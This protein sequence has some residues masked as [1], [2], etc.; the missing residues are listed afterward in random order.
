MWEKT[1]LLLPLPTDPNGDGY[2]LAICQTGGT[3][4]AG[5]GGGAPTCTAGEWC[6]SSSTSASGSQNSCAYTIQQS[7]AMSNAWEAYVCDDDTGGSSCTEAAE[8]GD[9]PFNVNHPP[10]IGTVTIGPSY[11]SSSSVNPGNDTTGAVY[12]QVAVTD[13]D[14]EAPQDTID[15][16]VCSGGTTG[17]EAST[18]TCTGGTLLC[19]D[20]GVTTGTNAQCTDSDLA[21][22]PTSHGSKNVKIYLRDSSSTPLQDDGS[23]NSH[24]YAVTDVTPTV[25]NFN[26]SQDPLI[27][28]AGLSTDQSFTATLTDENGY[29]DIESAFGAIYVSP[30]TLTGTGTCTTDSELNCYD[31]PSCELSGGSGSSVTVTCGTAGNPLTTWFNIAPDSSW[32]AHVSAVGAITYSLENRRK[33]HGQCAQRHFGGRGHDSLWHVDSWR[34]FR[35]ADNHLSECGK[36]CE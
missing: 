9:S 27:P 10:V 12:F 11:G 8:S 1:S 22:I 6:I 15:M 16:Y 35:P 36:H 31:T 3:I 34:H 7:D 13:P 18:A 33:F 26:I 24:S 5:A 32:K 23:N 14:S 17:F 28:Q 19:S 2:W 4:T 25:S 29:D 21:P 20:T 30:A